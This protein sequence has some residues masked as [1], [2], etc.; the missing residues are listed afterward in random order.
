MK[1]E[2]LSETFAICQLP[3]DTPIPL[4][5]INSLFFSVTKTGEELSI[6]CNQ[7]N[8]HNESR[9][10][11]ERDWRCFKVQGPL[12]FV[13]TGILASLT[14]PLAKDNISIFAISTFN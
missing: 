7:L 12:D 1:L 4:W 11:I 9:L 3:S 10:K 5:L 13:L 8:I 2:I 14:D 6:V